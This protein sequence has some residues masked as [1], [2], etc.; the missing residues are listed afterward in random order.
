MREEASSIEWGRSQRLGIWALIMVP[1]ILFASAGCGPEPSSK[2]TAHLKGKIMLNG[3]AIPSDARG[4]ITFKPTRSGQAKTT[5]ASIIEGN[6]DSPNT[7]KGPVK[8]YI[9]LQQETGKMISEAGGAP[10]AE[11]RSLVPPSYSGGFDLEV[12]QDNLEKHFDL[13]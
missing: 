11:V 10:Y 9:S 6:Y 3:E 7:P 5:F 12:D 1:T 13:K 8:A 2:P 4:S